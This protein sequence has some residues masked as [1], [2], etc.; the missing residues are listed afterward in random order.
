MDVFIRARPLCDSLRYVTSEV[1]IGVLHVR[2][3]HSLTHIRSMYTVAYPEFQREG[4]L[5]SG[6]LG[7]EGGG[8]RG[9]ALLVRYKKCVCV[10]VCVCG[11]DAV[12]FQSDTK[13]L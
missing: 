4:Y 12:R 9:G 3:N 10:C 8:G 1:L 13:T 2:N 6:I 7:G 11:E 5:R